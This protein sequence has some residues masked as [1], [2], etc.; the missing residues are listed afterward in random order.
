MSYCRFAEGDVYAYV[1]DGGVQFYVSD[2]KRELDR[3]C[4]TFNEAYQYARVLRDTH[5][6][7]V[8][9]H[10]IEALKADALEE[11]ARICGPD[12]AVAELEAE[13]DK[14]RV[15]LTDLRLKSCPSCGI[16]VENE[17][18]REQVRW[19]KK[20]DILHV[21]T[22]QEYIDQC[23]RER[24]MQVSI[25]ALDKENA[26]LRELVEDMLSCIEIRAAFLRPPTTGMYEQFA[27]RATEL[28]IEVDE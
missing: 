9:S 20:G 14:L 3:L 19:L 15:E 5:G 23:E 17:K 11:A 10:A 6:L 8:P 26:K 25:D 16:K 28:G 1:C 22:D 27:K 2:G 18:L 21:L 4:N 12:S 24:L 7:D 13:N